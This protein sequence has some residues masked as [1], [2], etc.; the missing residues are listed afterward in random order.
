MRTDVSGDGI[1]SIFKV[2]NQQSEK[3][4]AT[5]G[6]LAVK[7]PVTCSVDIRP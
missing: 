6:C 7:M 4:S 1:T 3:P 5:G 2:E